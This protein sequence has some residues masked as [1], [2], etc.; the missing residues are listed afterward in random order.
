MRWWTT[1][2]ATMALG[3]A[4]CAPDQKAETPEFPDIVDLDEDGFA[5]DEDCDDANPDV[6]PDALEVCDGIDNNCDALVDDADPSLD[7]TTATAFYE[8]DD[9]DGHGVATST[10]RACIQPDGFSPLNTDCLDSDPLV[11]PDGTEVCNGIDDDCDTLIDD[12]D[13]SVD[14]TTGVDAWVD[15]DSDG[16]G[17]PTQPVQVCAA[18]DGTALTAEDCDDTTSTRAPDLDEVCGDGVDNDCSGNDAGCGLHIQGDTTGAA[19]TIHTGSQIGLGLASRVLIHDQDRDGQNDLVVFADGFA[20]EETGLFRSR[21]YIAF[22]PLTAGATDVDTADSDPAV[23]TDDDLASAS[24]LANPGDL[25][26][27]GWDDLVYATT[28][29]LTFANHATGAT[30][31]LD[32]TWLHT[33]HPVGDVDGDGL[34]D[35]LI[36]DQRFL[37]DAHGQGAMALIFGSATIFDDL[38]A[39]STITEGH[40]LIIGAPYGSAWSTQQVAAPDSATALDWDG[41][42]L[43]DL[44]IGAWGS[45]T[46]GWSAVRL[47]R[48]ATTALPTGQHTYDTISDEYWAGLSPYDFINEELVAGDL[49]NDGYD[50]LVATETNV[51]GTIYVMFGGT[52]AVAS[53][54]AWDSRDVL[55]TGSEAGG[56]GQIGRRLAVADLDEDG[57]LDLVV[58][59]PIAPPTSSDAVLGFL[60]LDTTATMGHADAEIRIDSGVPAGQCSANRPFWSDL[61]GDGTP[62]L[63]LGCA[64]EPTGG[65]AHVFFG[66]DG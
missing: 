62:D 17:D 64:A 31:A 60:S 14:T 48:D 24:Q 44:A 19:V 18:G 21:G 25:D 41:D 40:P 34:A 1:G 16:H 46:E 8:D 56:E 4:A 37:V 59:D 2:L 35:V 33:I 28:D 36:G 42:G 66:N 55:I 61:S 38:A 22:G 12:D 65:Q 13:D 9:G 30:V 5:A 10:R 57:D 45:G 11:S 32:T 63:T 26:G 6:R 49:N 29:V 43:R 58:T 15:A 23:W 53:G 52:A 47:V 3:F 27:D 7:L 54:T 20:D 39:A 51:G 50:D